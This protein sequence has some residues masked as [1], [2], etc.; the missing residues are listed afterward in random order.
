[1]STSRELVIKT[2]TFDNPERVPRE[3]WAL[4]WCYTNHPQKMKEIE[5]KYPADFGY[6][7]SVYNPSS[8]EKGN[9]YEIGVAIDDW[10]CEFE[11]IFAGIIGEVKEPL[12]ADLKDWDKV[13]PPYETLPTNLTEARDKVN[14]Y[15]HESDKFIRMPN[16]A[17]PWERL[18]FLR[19]SV[20]AMYDIMDQEDELFKLLHKIHEFYLREM[21]FWASTDVDALFF[22]DDW[23]SQN[24]LLIPSTIWREIF[25][26]MYRDYCDIARSS[27][28]FI[29]MHSDGFIQEIYPDLIEIG[30]SAVNSQ[31]FCM[32]FDYL[33]KIAKGKITF[34]GE[35]DRQH[36]M[37]ALDFEIGRQAVRKI[38]E[39]LGTGNGGLIAQF[40][41]GPWSNLDM[42]FAIYDEW[43]KK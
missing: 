11:S 41:L 15:C 13:N 43:E 30:V 17:R 18:Q 3:L 28:K 36:I 1:M 40:E 14:K 32:D 12:L 34:W 20:L 9:M 4:P 7:P 5:E 37:C 25:K 35:I 42:A 31:L 24:Q 22:M 27:G 33:S 19:T 39:K 38:K 2:L 10:G 29:F 23:G 8:V 26:P 6:I 16:C 21:E